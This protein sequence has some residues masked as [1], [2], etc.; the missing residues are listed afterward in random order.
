LCQIAKRT[1]FAGVS[2][3]IIIGPCLND[4][5]SLMDARSERLSN[6]FR[7][8]FPNKSE[9]CAAVQLSRTSLIRIFAGSGNIDQ[10]V[11]N[12]C[13]RIG[14]PTGTVRC[15]VR[16]VSVVERSRYSCG[17][18]LPSLLPFL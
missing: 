6:N 7:H 1:Q 3:A 5:P 17:L 15:E 13:P 10:M 16:P 18:V 14:V 8:F 9:V 11:R 4:G 12:L 2:D